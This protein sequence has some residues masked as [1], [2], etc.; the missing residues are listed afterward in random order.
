MFISKAFV[1]GSYITMVPHFLSESIENPQS[2]VLP[3][4]LPYLCPVGIGLG[5]DRTDT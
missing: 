5:V 3:S 2:F 4:V 1:H